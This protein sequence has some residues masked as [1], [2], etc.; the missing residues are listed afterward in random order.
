MYVSCAIRPVEKKRLRPNHEMPTMPLLRQ[1]H[2]IH[3]R[4]A[5]PL[6][7]LALSFGQRPFLSPVRPI[8]EIIFVNRKFPYF[9]VQ[10]NVFTPRP[11]LQGPVLLTG[12][13]QSNGSSTFCAKVRIN[14]YKWWWIYESQSKACKIRTSTKWNKLEFLLFNFKT[15]ER[16]RERERGNKI[17][18]FTHKTIGN[19]NLPQLI[20]HWT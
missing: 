10:L 8:K 20:W 3:T 2:E 17:D 13:S 11:K 14:R 1:H 7:Y 16:T 6:Q 15:G 19:N 9:N 5:T 18:S 4:P 12:Q